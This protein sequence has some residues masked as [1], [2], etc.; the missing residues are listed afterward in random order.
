MWIHWPLALTGFSVSRH[1]L[2]PNQSIQQHHQE[3][4]E[5]SVSSG[6]V[7]YLQLVGLQLT[8]LLM[9]VSLGTRSICCN[10]INLRPF[11]SWR[12][13]S[14]DIVRSVMRTCENSSI[15]L[16]SYVTGLARSVAVDIGF[17]FV[18]SCVLVRGGCSNNGLDFALHGLTLVN[19]LELPLQDASVF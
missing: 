9:N 19:V 3:H 1:R 17:R 16:L 8:S 13:A 10:L 6:S 12:R 14:I 2:S 18:S 11:I 15:S 7:Q 4:T 5:M